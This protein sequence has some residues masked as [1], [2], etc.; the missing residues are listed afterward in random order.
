MSLGLY[1]FIPILV[2]GPITTTLYHIYYKKEISE[3]WE[4][5]DLE[6]EKECKEQSM[7]DSTYNIDPDNSIGSSLKKINKYNKETKLLIEEIK[8]KNINF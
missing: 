6:L 2:I 5:I 4:L 8:K 1:T 7:V 3:E